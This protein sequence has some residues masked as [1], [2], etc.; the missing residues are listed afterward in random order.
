[1]ES[2][3]CLD[4]IG[5]GDKVCVDCKTSKTPLWRSGPAGPKSLC[6]ACGIKYRKRRSVA[7]SDKKKVKPSP[8]TSSTNGDNRMTY[9]NRE[10]D[11]DDSGELKESDL[12]IRVAAVGKEAVLLRRQRSPMKKV[13]RERKFREVEEAACLLMSLSCGLIFG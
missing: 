4:P 12:R 13:K 3:S 5:D 10:K 2:A 8:S 6:N 7:G 11:D 9:R 1:M